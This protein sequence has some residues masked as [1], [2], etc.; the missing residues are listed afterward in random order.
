MH[1]CNVT[2]DEMLE[3]KSND[4]NNQ[5]NIQLKSAWETYIA[6]SSHDFKND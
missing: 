6:Q 5:P 4:V 2:S 1:K 3:K